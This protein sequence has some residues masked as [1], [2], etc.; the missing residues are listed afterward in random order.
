MENCNDLGKEQKCVTTLAFYNVICGSSTANTSV[1]E[2]EEEDWCYCS[3][4]TLEDMPEIS[5]LEI[6]ILMFGVC[7]LDVISMLTLPFLADI[8]FS[9]Q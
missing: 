3:R 5:V 1:V 2:E 8:I 9:S 7:H 4:D 6:V